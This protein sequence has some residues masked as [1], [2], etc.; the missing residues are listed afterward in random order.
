MQA[1]N[2]GNERGY[3][4]REVIAACERVTGRPIPVRIAPRRAGDA[5]SLRADSS[6][7]RTE[8]GWSPRYP[9]LGTMIEHAWAWHR[10][11]HA[12]GEPVRP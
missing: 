9:E 12:A 8:L 11:Q 10:R 5:A 6:R 3:S 1:F 2:L 4:V 7:A